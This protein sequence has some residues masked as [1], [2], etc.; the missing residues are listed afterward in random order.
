MKNKRQYYL[1]ALLFVVS[2]FRSASAATAVSGDV[3]ERLR[4]INPEALQLAIDDMKKMPGFNPSKAEADL[5]V[6]NPHYATVCAELDGADNEKALK[7]AQL[8]LTKQRS[9]QLPTHLLDMDHILVICFP[10][11]DTART[12]T[13]NDLCVFYG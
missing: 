4:W 5:N 1:L 2:L 13:T 12:A 3:R 6:I 7:D 8:L 9:I 10:L 11:G